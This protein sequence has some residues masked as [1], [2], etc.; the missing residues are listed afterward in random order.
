MISCDGLL[1]KH[2]VPTFMKIDIEGFDGTCLKSLTHR[3][4][5][6]L[7]TFITYEDPNFQ[8]ENED[9]A[10]VMDYMT[11]MG[12]SSFKNIQE[13]GMHYWKS[14]ES[15][16][17]WGDEVMDY[18]LGKQWK[19]SDEALEDGKACGM[20]WKHTDA[21][22]QKDDFKKNGQFGARNFCNF[23]AMMGPSGNANSC[24]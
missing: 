8:Q 1:K 7:P 2:G 11:T 6:N 13:K 3:C 17:G 12:Y 20:Q 16:Y 14:F 18:K 9:A 23:H 19:T 5:Q 4:A 24:N 15:P 22:L 21:A 10:Q